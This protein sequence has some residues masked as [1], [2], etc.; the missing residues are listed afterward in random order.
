MRNHL[1]VICIVDISVVQI[2]KRLQMLHEYNCNTLYVCVC[3]HVSHVKADV[4]HKELFVAAAVTRFQQ[5][6]F[7]NIDI[8]F[9]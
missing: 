1:S 7:N 2:V 6:L 9:M 4:L 8:M 5:Q 3:W